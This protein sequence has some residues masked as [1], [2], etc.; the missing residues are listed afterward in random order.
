MLKQVSKLAGEVNGSNLPIKVQEA[1]NKVDSSSSSDNNTSNNLNNNNGDEDTTLFVG[2]L[3]G[4]CV[5]AD[6]EGLFDIFGVIDDI[7]VKIIRTSKQNFSYAFVR[8]ENRESALMAFN[9]LRDNLMLGSYKLR[10][11]WAFRNKSLH[12]G[13]SKSFHFFIFT[14]IINFNLF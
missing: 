14:N 10:L 6:L 12:I 7:Q 3:P 5:P 1:S 13:N 11:G 2:D 9:Q 4:N 8:Y